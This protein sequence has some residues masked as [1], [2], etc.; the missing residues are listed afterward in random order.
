MEFKNIF[1]NHNVSPF[2]FNAI[3]SKYM[4]FPVKHTLYKTS[5]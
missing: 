1:E 5:I 4:H 3:G 2:H